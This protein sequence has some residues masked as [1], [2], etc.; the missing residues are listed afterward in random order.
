MTLGLAAMSSQEEVAKAAVSEVVKDDDA[1]RDMLR[2]ISKA[3]SRIGRSMTADDML[4]LFS[5]L[6]APT[7]EGV[8]LVVDDMT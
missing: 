8:R 1:V 6:K 3:E 7:T 4:A 5:E 2:A